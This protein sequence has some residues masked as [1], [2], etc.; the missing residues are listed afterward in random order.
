MLK[1]SLLSLLAVTTLTSLSAFAGSKADLETFAY[2]KTNP[3]A[4]GNKTIYDVFLGYENSTTTTF[5]VPAGNPNN[6]LTPSGLNAS[7]LTT[8]FL[9]GSVVNGCFKSFENDYAVK[10]CGVAG[11]TNITWHV[12]VPTAATS[13]SDVARVDRLDD[14]KGTL[15]NLS[16]GGP[17]PVE[18]SSFDVAVSKAKPD[19]AEVKW[20]TASEK[21][22]SHF[23]VEDSIDGSNFTKIISQAGQGN[24]STARSYSILTPVLSPGMHYIRLKQV[25]LDGTETFMQPKTAIIG[26]AS[27]AS[28]IFYPIPALSGTP[29]NLEVRGASNGAI[30]RILDVNGRTVREISASAKNVS[31]DGMR[32]GVYTVLLIDGSITAQKKLVISE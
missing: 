16:C 3:R 6:F 23:D 15:P 1:K 18:L 29:L 11:N 4:D 9:G 7:P 20:T 21:N 27:R 22:S 32:S 25:D 28:M 5:N 13:N 30:V 26:S 2:C 24:S 17:L 8:Q 12:K 31:T 10:V 19:Q 14:C